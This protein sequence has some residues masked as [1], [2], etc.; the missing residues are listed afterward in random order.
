MRIHED[1]PLTM[2]LKFIIAMIGLAGVSATAYITVLRD[3]AD[4]HKSNAAQDTRLTFLEQR[5]ADQREMLTEMR[6]DLKA[7][8]EQTALVIEMLKAN[9]TIGRE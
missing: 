8:R 7:N 1:K 2:P 9:R 3:I 6:A 5:S 4:E